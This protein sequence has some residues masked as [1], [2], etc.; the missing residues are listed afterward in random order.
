MIEKNNNESGTKLQKY[1]QNES[2]TTSKQC[3]K[4]L[5]EFMQFT[6]IEVAQQMEL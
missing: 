5:P 4:T 2:S 1:S 3:M 6:T